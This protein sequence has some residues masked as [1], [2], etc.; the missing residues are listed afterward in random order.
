[1]RSVLHHWCFYTYE[2]DEIVMNLF[3][4]WFVAAAL[5]AKFDKRT[6]RRLQPHCTRVNQLLARY[7][8]RDYTD[9]CTMADKQAKSLCDMLIEYS[10]IEAVYQELLDDNLRL[11]DE[12][13]PSLVK[14]G[15]TSVP[16][17]MSKL[18]KLSNL[19]NAEGG[20]RPLSHL[21]QLKT[22]KSTLKD[23]PAIVDTLD[24]IHWQG[25]LDLV[26]RRTKEAEEK[27][28]QVLTE[29]EM[30][31]LGDTLGY[32]LTLGAISFMGISHMETSEVGIA[33]EFLE[34][35]VAGYTRGLGADH[36]RTMEVKKHLSECRARVEEGESDPSFSDKTK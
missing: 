7:V 23:V 26:Q 16:R 15:E 32:M 13:L 9:T 34:R 8:Q 27:F 6:R 36:H 1:M 24:I 29:Y 25:I 11:W 4:G 19:V 28:L 20:L 35:A 22:T 21:Y 30:V 33:A 10:K 3:A 14:A 17:V 5:G 18:N 2:K 31:R 12:I